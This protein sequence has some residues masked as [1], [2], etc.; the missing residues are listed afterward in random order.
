MGGSV[1]YVK[2]NLHFWEERRKKDFAAK[3]RNRHTIQGVRTRGGEEGISR[4][5]YRKTDS[6][7]D[8]SH[9][10][11]NVNRESRIGTQAQA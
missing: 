6:N 8:S 7:S 9:N 2:T 4:R 3:V 1:P 5:E 11:V 10:F